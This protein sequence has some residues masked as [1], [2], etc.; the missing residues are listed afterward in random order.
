LEAS[1]AV[2]HCAS[3]ETAAAKSWQSGAAETL[4][5]A[6]VVDHLLRAVFTTSQTPAAPASALP[7]IEQNL[8]RLRSELKSMVSTVFTERSLKKRCPD[9]LKEYPEIGKS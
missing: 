6:R 3:S 8:C 9:R 5:T 4:K 1:F 2:I 7:Q